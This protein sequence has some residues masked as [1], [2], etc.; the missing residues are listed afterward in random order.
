MPKQQNYPPRSMERFIR[1]KWVNIYGESPFQFYK[2]PLSNLPAR[3]EPAI[4][5]RLIICA[6]GYHTIKH[7]PS[8]VWEWHREYINM[9]LLLKLEVADTNSSP[10]NMGWAADKEVWRYAR[11]LENLGNL[12]REQ[13]RALDYSGKIDV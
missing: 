3:W 13:V 10:Q 9:N 8:K 6:N 2:W 12:T 5:G 7:N 11:V 1:Y 4:K